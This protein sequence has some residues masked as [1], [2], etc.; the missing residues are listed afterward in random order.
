MVRKWLGVFHG[1]ANRFATVTLTEEGRNQISAQKTDP[2]NG[3][4]SFTKAKF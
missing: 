3:G 1:N 4:K 2:E